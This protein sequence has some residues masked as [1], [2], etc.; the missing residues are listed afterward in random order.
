V[1]FG[2][3]MKDGTRVL[4]DGK[5][6]SGL[7]GGTLSGMFIGLVQLLIGLAVGSDDFLGF[8]HPP[9]SI[10]IIFAMAFGALLGD[11]LGSFIKRR[12]GRERGAQFHGLDQYD[13]VLGA[14]I[15]LFILAPGW[16]WETY[17]YGK[18]IIGLLTI[19]I[20]TPFLHRAVN[21]LGYKMGKKDVPW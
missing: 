9:Y 19:I 20:V 21:I 18:H 15:M 4:G 14:F 13:F 17:L 3:T 6:W 2:R 1:D 16:T 7:L 8:G 10:I 12:L 5:T 11:M